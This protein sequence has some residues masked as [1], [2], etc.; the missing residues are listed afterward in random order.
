[1]LCAISGL[2]EQLCL[3]IVHPPT[4]HLPSFLDSSNRAYPKQGIHVVSAQAA[5]GQADHKASSALQ[6][7]SAQAG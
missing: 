2:L 7:V 5:K 4:S 3:P 6:N 1:M